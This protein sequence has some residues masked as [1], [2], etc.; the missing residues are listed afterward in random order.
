[1][2]V[3]QALI[4]ALDTSTLNDVSKLYKV[5]DQIKVIIKDIDEE[6]WKEEVWDKE[7]VPNEDYL[8]K[9]PGYSCD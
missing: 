9:K 3:R 5:N 8:Y 4:Y 2:Y 6:N 7:I 1:M